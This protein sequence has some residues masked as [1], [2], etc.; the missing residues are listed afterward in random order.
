M[1]QSYPLSVFIIAKDEEDR[2]PESIKSVIDWADEVIVI[3]SG[4]KDK[5]VAISEEFGASVIY[6]E[7]NGYGPQK[8]FG[9]GKCRNDWILNIDADEAISPKLKEEI[10]Q[11]FDNNIMLF[12]YLVF[13]C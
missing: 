12:L 13:L 1:Q 9:E 2:I 11:L 3:D 6:N 8:V 10:Q 7:W 5:T 4:S